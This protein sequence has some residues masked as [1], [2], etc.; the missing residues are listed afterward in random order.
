ME[1]PILNIIVKNDL[2]DPNKIDTIFSQV[3]NRS[4]EKGDI[5]QK[6]YFLDDFLPIGP[7]WL[8]LDP[9]VGVGGGNAN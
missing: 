4:P 8:L 1:I 7:C 6:M 5:N 2:A 3:T 9:I